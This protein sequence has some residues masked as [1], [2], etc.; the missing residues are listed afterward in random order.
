MTYTPGK[1]LLATIYTDEIP[2][3]SEYAPWEHFMESAIAEA[4]LT[5]VGKVMHNFPG[6]GFTGVICLTESHISIHTWPEY[7]LCTCDI[8]LSNFRRNNDKTGE[9]LMDGLR[10]FLKATSCE[11]QEVRR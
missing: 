8:F 4:S 10:L 6:G 7:G 3:L 9:A 11:L 2:L 5:Q 1:H